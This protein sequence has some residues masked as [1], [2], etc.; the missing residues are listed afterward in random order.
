MRL[1]IDIDEKEYKTIL[2]NAKLYK[3]KSWGS[4]EIWD[5]IVNGIP[6]P[7]GHGDL[8]DRSKL[9]IVNLGIGDYDVWGVEDYA[10]ADAPTVIAADKESNNEIDN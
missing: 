9:K 8:I 5:A 2:V 6:L 1:V 7:K 4:A 10:I 3:D